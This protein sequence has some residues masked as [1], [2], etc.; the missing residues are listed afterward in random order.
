[1]GAL[2]RSLADLTNTLRLPFG[3][4]LCAGFV[5]TVWSGGARVGR[6]IHS[7]I[8]VTR[9]AAMWDV[10]G[11]TGN[12]LHALLGTTQERRGRCVW[13]RGARTDV[14]L[15]CYVNLPST[16]E[17]VWGS[18]TPCSSAQHQSSALRPS[19]PTACTAPCR[20]ALQRAEPPRTRRP[21]SG[22]ARPS[23]SQ[24]RGCSGRTCR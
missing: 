20:H 23:F 3:R 24:R 15:R 7:F 17:A 9:W 8:R 21:D 19:A 22:R 5:P 4:S 6:S 10:G 16:E 18:P 13:W 12:R 1:M 11:P 2:A 14:L